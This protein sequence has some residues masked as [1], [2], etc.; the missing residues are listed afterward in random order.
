[1]LVTTKVNVRLAVALAILTALL[2]AAI[3]VQVILATADDV[4]DLAVPA[5]GISAAA[6]LLLA[7][8]AP[9]LVTRADLQLARWVPWLIGGL[10]A[11]VAIVP[12][13]LVFLGSST[14]AASWYRTLRVP[15]GTEPFWDLSLVLRSVDCA[16]FGFDVYA[17]NNGCLQDPSIYGPG[18]LWLRFVPFDLFS[19]SAAPALGVIA[20]I[21]SSL[22][23]VWLARMTTGRGQVVLLVAAVAAPWQLLLERGNLDIFVI[24]AAVLLVF[25]VRRWDTTWAWAVGA[26]AIWLMG[27]WKYY[28]FALGLMLIPVLRLRRGWI[29]LG[30]YALA[31]G[32][33][34]ALTWDNF[35]FSQSSNADMPITY[36]V[37]I[38]GRVPLVARMLVGDGDPSSY[39]RG[40]LLV[41]ALALSAFAWGVA[42]ALLLKRLRLPEALLALGGSSLF[43]ASVLVGGFGYAYKA[44]FLLLTVPLLAR[45]LYPRR[46]ILLYSSLVMLVL[47]AV[48]TVVVWNTA[49]ATVAGVVA[50]SFG[51]GASLT[52][53]LRLMLARP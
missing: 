14:W 43:L 21:G 6:V 23:L 27:T 2:V 10:S 17:A 52:V 8:L 48:A 39:Q 4:V 37:V 11:I 46:R 32:A 16:R 53:T 28:P 38:L 40:D 3:Q 20:I 25:P 34:L 36:D 51:L 9:A 41:F 31:T 44:A 47:V 50:G 26:A 12:A 22:A 29:V 42:I 30:G 33:Y 1:M 7:F 15:Q 13:V 49:L 24:W 5:T 35:V 18:S 45:P 19:K